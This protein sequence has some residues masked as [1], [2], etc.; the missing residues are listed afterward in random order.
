M[1]SHRKAESDDV[2]GGW[3]PMKGSLVSSG[4]RQICRALRLPILILNSR[5]H[6][7]GRTSGNSRWRSDFH[8]NGDRQRNGFPRRHERLSGGGMP[9]SGCLTNQQLE[10][11]VPGRRPPDSEKRPRFDWK[12]RHDLDLQVEAV[13]PCHIDCGVRQMQGVTRAR[14]AGI[15]IRRAKGLGTSTRRRPRGAADAL[16]R[17]VSASSMSHRV[18]PPARPAAVIC[19]RPTLPVMARTC[20]TARVPPPNANTARK[21]QAVPSISGQPRA[22]R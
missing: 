17:L 12:L 18:E 8:A 15:R 9:I 4:A 14:S 5:F 1:P 3:R 16:D 6:E 7:R 19:T 11:T 22:F 21:I 13:K 10:V 20:C 2:G